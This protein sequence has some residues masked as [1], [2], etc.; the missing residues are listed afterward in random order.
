MYFTKKTQI[1]KTAIFIDNGKR[2][3]ETAAANNILIKYHYLIR[4]KIK[5]RTS[6]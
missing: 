3:T 1:P 5:Y 2:L 4:A 6:T